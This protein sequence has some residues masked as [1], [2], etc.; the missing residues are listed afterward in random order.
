M[1]LHKIMTNLFSGVDLYF[2]S[3][4]SNALAALPNGTEA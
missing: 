1:H 2:F 3:E 4:S